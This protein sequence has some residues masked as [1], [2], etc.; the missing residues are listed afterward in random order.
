LAFYECDANAVQLV[1]FNNSKGVF[2]NKKLREAVS[3]ALD[4]DAIIMGAKEGVATRAEAPILP[5]YKGYPE[6]FKGN[7]FDVEKAKQ[8]MAEAGYA[9]GLK[10][11]MK[12]IDSE[13]YT[14]PTEIIKEQLRKIGID[15]QIEVMARGKW[16]QDVV[17]NSDYEI[18][19]WAIVAPVSDADFCVYSQFYSKNAGGNG[20][21]AECKIPELD[22]LLDQGRTSQNDAERTQIYEKVCN[23]IKDEN[24]LV[25]ILIGKRQ[26]ATNKDLKGVKINPAMK[27]YTYDWSWE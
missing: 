6:N 13:I 25:P 23:I 19:F 26:Y 24:V 14:K 3:Y 5:G 1:T 18:T 12:T 10:V 20:N 21:F 22:K 11:V 15:V 7:Q 27:M 17:T 4:K 2:T 8:L 16:M 9:N